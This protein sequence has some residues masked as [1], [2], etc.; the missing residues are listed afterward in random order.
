MPVS[1]THLDVYKRQAVDLAF[2]YDSEIIVEE[3]IEGFE[4]GCAVL[5]NDEL[6][7][8]RVDEIELSH[9]FFDYKEKYTPVSYTHLDVYKRQTVSSQIADG[10]SKQ[11]ASD[12]SQHQQG[13]KDAARNP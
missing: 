6:I 11:A 3:N 2:R 5:G 10:S 1:Y 9:G 7:L 12:G 13:Q 4:V 8:G